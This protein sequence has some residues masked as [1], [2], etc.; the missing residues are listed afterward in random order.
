MSLGVVDSA[1]GRM[2]VLGLFGI[3]VVLSG[4]FNYVPLQSTAPDPGATIRAHLT[5]SASAALA[6]T[7]GPGIGALEGRVLSR[8]D[9]GIELAVSAARFRFGGGSQTRYGE[10]LT[11]PRFGIAAVEQRKLSPIRTA[12]LG[13]GVVLGG[14]GLLMA[15]DISSGGDGGGGVDKPPANWSG[16]W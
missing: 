7:V 6:P 14:I 12:L 8:D 15:I 10:P 11:V 5:D 3:S 16:P 1:E 9:T 13:G 4:C 2:R